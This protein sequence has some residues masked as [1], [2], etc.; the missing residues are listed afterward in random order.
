MSSYD[1]A[2]GAVETKVGNEGDSPRA[3]GA[4]TP[5]EEADTHAMMAQVNVKW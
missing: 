3:P 5:E 2:G 4:C 1:A